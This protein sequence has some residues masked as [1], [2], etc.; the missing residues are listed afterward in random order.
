MAPCHYFS[1]FE[2]CPHMAFGYSSIHGLLIGHVFNAFN[3]KAWR[4]LIFFFMRNHRRVPI[5][6][7]RINVEYN[8]TFRSIQD[9]GDRI[10]I[11]GRSR[12]EVA[13]RH[14]STGPYAGS[15]TVAVQ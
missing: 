15:R 4:N 8:T 11:V 10:P 9:Q 13:S 3:P 6:Q 12:C 1:G 7:R 2:P 14:E 5:K